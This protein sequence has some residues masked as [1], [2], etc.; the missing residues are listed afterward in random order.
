MQIKQTKLSE[1]PRGKRTS[2]VEETPALISL[3]NQLAAG[4]I[5]EAV[6]IDLSSPSERKAGTSIAG[7]LR[8]RINGLDLPWRI[9]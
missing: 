3:L 4:Q 1:I 5:K 9:K 7:A 2:I 6:T 8:R